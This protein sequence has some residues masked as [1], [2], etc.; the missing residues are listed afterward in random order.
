[1][2]TIHILDL[3]ALVRRVAIEQPK[4]HPYIFAV[5]KSKKPTQKRIVQQIAKLMGT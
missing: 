2:P 3:A 5:D 4:V 1:M